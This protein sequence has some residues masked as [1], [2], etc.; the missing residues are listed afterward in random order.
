M[1]KDS[2]LIGNERV[3]LRLYHPGGCRAPVIILCH[4]LCG[5]QAWML[6]EVACYFVGAGFAVVTF[7]YRGFGASE[8]ERGR[9]SMAQQEE[10]LCGVIDWLQELK[11]IDS[12]RIGLWGVGLG[13]KSLITAALKRPTVRAL[14]CLQPWGSGQ[15][16]FAESERAWRD[17]LHLQTYMERER[18][19]TGSELWLTLPQ[20]LKK[21]EARQFYQLCQKRFPDM[22]GRLPIAIIQDIAQ[23]D[24]TVLAPE[25]KQP[26]F[27]VLPG[28]QSLSEREESRLFYQALGGSKALSVVEGAGYYDLY[29][30]PRLGEVLRSQLVWFEFRLKNAR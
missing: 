8:G 16:W 19:T 7:D 3:S 23:C 20:L 29:A 25:V 15:A 2:F 21:R 1:W 11:H 5:V 26:T 9:L 10:D 24:I 13:C 14:T 30:Q 12:S 22:P 27:V 18:K 28:V 4:D 17:L 6:P